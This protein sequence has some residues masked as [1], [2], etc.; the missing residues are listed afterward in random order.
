MRHKLIDI[1]KDVKTGKKLLISRIHTSHPQIRVKPACE[2][3]T[4]KNPKQLDENDGA[5]LEE[6]SWRGYGLCLWRV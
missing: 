6:I 3:H 1:W 4:R 2:M 5:A